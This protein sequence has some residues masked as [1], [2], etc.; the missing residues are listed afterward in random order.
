MALQKEIEL[1]N[2]VIVNYHRI[3]NLMK[4]TNQQTI[5]EIASYISKAKRDEEQEAI[6]TAE[7]GN[8]PDLN[9]FINTE[10]INKE[11]IENENIEDV[12]TY[13]KE[14]I[15]KYKNAQDI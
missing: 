4:I 8:A 11:Y 3:V 5:I 14:N 12:Y 15:D 7:G 6:K 13:L 9:I 1:E 2:G 10:Y